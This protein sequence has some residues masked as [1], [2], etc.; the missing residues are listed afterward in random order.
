ME[1]NCNKE[2][3]INSIQLDIREIRNDIKILLKETSALKVKSILWGSV[4]GA[5]L[6]LIVGLML[7]IIGVR[8][9]I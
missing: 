7:Y 5:L 8:G 9:T 1:H 6:P 4:G 2:D 3:S